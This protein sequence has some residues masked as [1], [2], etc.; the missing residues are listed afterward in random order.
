[1]CPT[2]LRSNGQVLY[3]GA[4]GLSWPL[5]SLFTVSP[6]TL[7]CSPFP[8]EV[9]M[10]LL[11]LKSSLFCEGFQDS[12]SNLYHLLMWFPI[13]QCTSSSQQIREME[14]CAGA[15]DGERKHRWSQSTV[16][17]FV[18]FSERVWLC[19]PCLFKSPRSSDSPASA[20][21][22]A[23]LIAHITTSGSQAIT[24]SRFDLNLLDYNYI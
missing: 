17:L 14:L 8:W 13:T 1:M 2:T 11:I 4:N 21:Q 22:L 7:L 5:L 12:G 3:C 10:Y 19:C 16:V 9:T 15:R 24:E 18:C 6:S 23:R 20:S